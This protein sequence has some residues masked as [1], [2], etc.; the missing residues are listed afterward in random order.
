MSEMNVFLTV[1]KAG[2]SYDGTAFR[3]PAAAVGVFLV[4][5]KGVLGCGEALL[6]VE[7]TGLKRVPCRG[8]KIVQR[9]APILAL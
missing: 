7:G 9:P 2:L 4:S 3:R 5:E 6:V 1:L 8:R